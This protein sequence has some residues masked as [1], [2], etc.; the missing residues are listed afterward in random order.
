M[1]PRLSIFAGIDDNRPAQGAFD[2]WED[3]AD[4]LEGQSAEQARPDQKGATL[5]VSPCIYQDQKPRRKAY[6]VS[7]NWF[8][9]DID[10]K[11]GNRPG[12]TICDMMERCEEI[13]LPFVIYTTTSSRTDAE[14]F[15]LMFPLDRTVA[16]DDHG[17]LWASV[18]SWLGCIDPQTK[19]VSRLFI[20]PRLWDGADNAFYR[21]DHGVPLDVGTIRA[22]Y[23]APAAARRSSINFGGFADL[24]GLQPLPAS[25]VTIYG[26]IVSQTALAKAQQG[27]QGGRMFGFLVST[28]TR[29]MLKGWAITPDQ[30]A[31]IGLELARSMNRQTA[32]VEH[33]ARNAY[34]RAVSAYAERKQSDFAALIDN[35]AQRWMAGGKAA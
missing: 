29:A 34:A 14:C 1:S 35:S 11:G 13:D 12:S 18:A 22:A 8:A 10:N 28:A 7:W 19:D 23:P 16:A 26:D 4:F 31:D 25:D 21:S 33:D 20:V 27:E 3:F 6:A 17:A 24:S 5:C 9:A 15:R 32:D 30:L 2:T